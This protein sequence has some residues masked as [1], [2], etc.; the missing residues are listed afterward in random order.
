M[1]KNTVPAVVKSEGSGASFVYHF[2]FAGRTWTLDKREAAPAASWRIRFKLDGRN[3]RKAL[4]TSDVKLA[5]DRAIKLFIKPAMIGDWSKIFPPPKP[6]EE[7][8]RLATLQEI[9]DC[10][11]AS[12]HLLLDVGAPAVAACIGQLRLVV[13]EALGIDREQVGALSSSV[14]TLD[15]AVNFQ[16]KFCAR[17]EYRG[18]RLAENRARVS[19]NSKLRQARAVLSKKARAKRIYE[20]A[21]LRLPDLTGFLS[22]PLLDELKIDNYQLPETEIL[23]G[24]WRGAASLKETQP[25]VWMVWH[26]INATGLRR[27][28]LC[29]MR[30]RWF[31]PGLVRTPFE[32][33]FVPKGKRER[34]IP[35]RADVEQLAREHAITNG[36]PCG[37]ADRVLPGTPT[38][39]DGLFRSLAAWMKD[40]GWTRRQKAHELRKV[41]ASLVCEENDAYS[42]QL[43]L[44]HQQ[45]TTTQRYAARPKVTPVSVADRYAAPSN[46]VSMGGG[47]GSNG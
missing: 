10:Y 20:A 34:D 36:W 12:A 4:K 46:V 39:R 30:W 24:L 15:L 27:R 22:C 6:A 16:R 37:A 19:A 40:N 31:G 45:I 26:M 47:S 35:V 33:D 43:V 17:R 25:A 13:A 44:G 18:G 42:A 5:K 28:E 14:L 2:E 9:M 21:G 3:V 11:A 23:T 41:F 1:E 29:A 38:E 8:L 32:E 7:R